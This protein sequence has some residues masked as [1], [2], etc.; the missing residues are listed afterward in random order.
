MGKKPPVVEREDADVEIPVV[1][2]RAGVEVD[3]GVEV[4][5]SG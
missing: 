4:L 2:L 1:S 5:P 3:V